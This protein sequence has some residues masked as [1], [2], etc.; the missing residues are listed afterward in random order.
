MLC[1]APIIEGELNHIIILP[2]DYNT[3]QVWVKA[4]KGGTSL[5][6]LYLF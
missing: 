6:P 5:C 1:R 3:E 4:A 2:D